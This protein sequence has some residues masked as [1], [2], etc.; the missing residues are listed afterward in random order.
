MGNNTV[1]RLLQ[2][3][4][5]HSLEPADQI[6][7]GWRYCTCSEHDQDCSCTEIIDAVL[8]D[9]AMLDKL[10]QLLMEPEDKVESD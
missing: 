3:M 8:V 7:K 2:E 9:N 1:L 5:L 4:Q 6:P 10:I